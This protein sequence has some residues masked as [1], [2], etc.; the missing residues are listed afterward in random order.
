MKKIEGII[1]FNQFK[2]LIEIYVNPIA[3]IIPEYIAHTEIYDKYTMNNRN[4]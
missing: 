3:T 1:T 4:L 2:K